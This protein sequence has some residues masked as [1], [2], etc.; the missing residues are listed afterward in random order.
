MNKYVKTIGMTAALAVMV[1]LSA[2]AATSTTTTTDAT[3]TTAQ[4][5]QAD[6]GMKPGDRGGRGGFGGQQ[7]ISDSVLTLLNLDRDALNEKLAAGSTLA[8]IATAQGVTEEA[9]KS[10]LAAAF[11]E[12][13]T[14]EKEQFDANLDTL[15]NSEQPLKGDQ[16]HGFGMGHQLSTIATALNLTEDELRTQLESGTTIAAIAEAQG[17]STDTLISTLE[18][19]ITAQIDQAVTDGKLTE[20][21]ATAQKEKVAEQAEKLVSGEFAL[22]GGGMGHGGKGGPRADET[23]TTDSTTTDNA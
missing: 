3:S 4:V 10:A 17:I 12:R 2:F 7:F 14:K 8:E 18:A 13:Q 1:P 16:G 9:L 20:E 23:S 11:Q 5:Q 21:Q 22:K 19:A 15:I 6:Q